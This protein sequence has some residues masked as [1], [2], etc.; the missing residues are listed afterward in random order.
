MAT[1]TIPWGDGSGD[2]IYFTYSASQGDQTV[3]VSS[4]ANG[5]TA[6]QKVITFVSTV[7]DISRSLTVLQESG[8]D[9]V[10]ITWNDV[11]IT[12]D[13]TAIAY[14]VTNPTYVQDGLVL[15]LDG[16]DKGPDNSAWV[17]RING[18]SFTNYG[19]VFNSEHVY[20]DG[21]S[22]LQNSSFDGI[23]AS[24]GTIE[25]VCEFENFTSTSV[26]F[27]GKSGCLSF[28]VYQQRYIWAA[29]SSF[30]TYSGGSATAGSTSISAAKA[31]RNG[32]AL[33]ASS[34]DNWSGPNSYNWVGR[35]NSGSYFQG[36]IYC[37]RIY[38]RQLT[39]EEIMANLSVDNE[40]F[41]LGLTI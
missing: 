10:S 2:N 24:V 9:L 14:P 13:D 27:M 29:G 34:G 40:R 7:G 15:L 36:K 22:Y 4:D 18:H 30:A 19:A 5:G 33:T 26:L 28:G 31:L 41:N 12:Y 8:M 20:L 35:R 25:V 11:C 38:N 1:T 3:L 6:R 23:S 17:D 16:I 37:I 21:S 39:Q 32:A